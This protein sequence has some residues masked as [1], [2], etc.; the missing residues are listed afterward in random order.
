MTLSLFG[1]GRGAPDVC[2]NGGF[3]PA[4]MRSIPDSL[5]FPRLPATAASH[6]KP[7][8]C[9]QI[10]PVRRSLEPSRIVTARRPP[11]ACPSGGRIH[12]AVV[13]SHR[14]SAQNRSAAEIMHLIDRLRR[15]RCP[16]ELGCGDEGSAKAASCSARAR[17][18]CDAHG[19]ASWTGTTQIQLSATGIRGMS[20][21]Y[22]SKGGG[23]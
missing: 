11:E 3:F 2:D 5:I 6:S 15:D 22:K 20:V 12:P 10:R 8:S 1:T 19:L 7:I 21:S 13:G 16:H 18:S 9:K 17:R 14:L 23:P 4:S